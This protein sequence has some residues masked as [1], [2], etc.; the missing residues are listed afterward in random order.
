MHAQAASLAAST[1]GC[2]C[3]CSQSV[4]DGAAACLPAWPQGVTDQLW[5]ALRSETGQVQSMMDLLRAVQAG[6]VARHLRPEV[7]PL[8]LGCIAPEDSYEVQVRGWVVLVLG[9]PLGM[10]LRGLPA[11]AGAVWGC[12][13]GWSQVAC[14]VRMRTCLAWH[15]G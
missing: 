11:A 12:R 5:Q 15:D 2:A 13:G 10:M 4:R 3:V 9:V 14:P 1:H 6:G 7:W 8:L